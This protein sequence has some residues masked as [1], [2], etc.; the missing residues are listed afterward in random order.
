MDLAIEKLSDE[1]LIERLAIMEE[2]VPRRIIEHAAAR[3][4]MLESKLIA[5][6][7]DRHSWEL[8]M[9]D[10][11]YWLP[12]H[13]VMIL[14]LCSSERAGFALADALRVAVKSGSFVAD[15]LS[16]AW[17]S[18]AGN[19]PSSVLPVFESLLYGRSHDELIRETSAEVLIVAAQ[20]GGAQKLEVTLQQIAAIAA[21]KQEPPSFRQGLAYLLL[22]FP[23]LE[24]RTLIE[25][26]VDIGF[27]GIPGYSQ[28]DVDV[29]FERMIDG[30]QLAR[31][32]DPWQFYSDAAIAARRQDRERALT[33]IRSGTLFARR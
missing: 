23:R 21:D 28:D 10:S 31:W 8:A 17:P 25:S 13:C 16:H 24:H 15:E 19:K 5:I 27:E 1:S 20:R 3:G 12:F 32:S 11:G 29:A 2:A 7:K 26:F 18:L 14:G 30:E 9:W 33:W 4:E 6:A 22:T